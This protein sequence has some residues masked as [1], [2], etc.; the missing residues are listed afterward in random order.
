MDPQNNA[1]L[2]RGL[3]GFVSV[4]ALVAVGAVHINKLIP[5]LQILGE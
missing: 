2:P 1:F 5:F 3:C 4:L